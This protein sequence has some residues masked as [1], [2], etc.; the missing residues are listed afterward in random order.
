MKKPRVA[1]GLCLALVMGMLASAWVLLAAGCDPTGTTQVVEQGKVVEQKA[2]EA[3]TQANLKV[4]DTA[5][6][7]FY[8]QSGKWPTDIGQLKEFFGG[9]IPV[10]P[11]GGTYYIMMVNGQAKAGVRQQ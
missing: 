7:A 11:S 3:A 2:Y 8:M 6:Q 5:I 1:K 9:R 4:I 10:D